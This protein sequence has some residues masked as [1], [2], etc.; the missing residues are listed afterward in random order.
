M[1]YIGS[2]TA[3]GI[4]LTNLIVNDQRASLLKEISVNLPDINLNDRQLC[5]F[6]LLAIGGFSPL[7][8]FMTRSDYEPVLDRMRL[9]DDTL[10]P[11][12]ICLD[13]GE[14]RAR[15]L[16]AGQSVALRDGEGFLLAVMHIEDIWSLDR[17]KEASQ[18]Y[19]TLDSA[20]PGTNYLFNKTG[21]TYIGGKLEVVTTSAENWRW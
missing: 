9:E 18:I 7:Q 15:N 4:S 3:P 11:I 21:D 14:V 12:P 6:E 8:G 19:G 5:D 17:R 10:W 13:I 16:E 2:T 20:H 1:P